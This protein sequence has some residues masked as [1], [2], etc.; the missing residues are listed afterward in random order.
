MLLRSRLGRWLLIRLG[1]SGTRLPNRIVESKLE[2]KQEAFPSTVYG[3][4][5]YSDDGHHD[6]AATAKYRYGAAIVSS[7]PRYGRSA[8]GTSIEPSSR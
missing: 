3:K 8:E 6:A 2:D 5:I 4:R 1:S 7:P